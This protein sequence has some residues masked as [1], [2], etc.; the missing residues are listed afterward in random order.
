MWNVSNFVSGVSSVG[1]YSGT[2]TVLTIM[3][4][5]RG[6]TA[7]VLIVFPLLLNLFMVGPSYS[8]VVLFCVY[9][10]VLKRFTFCGWQFVL[11]LYGCQHCR[12][13]SFIGYVDLNG[14]AVWGA[15]TFGRRDISA[16]GV[17]CFAWDR[18]CVGFNFA[19]GSM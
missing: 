13:G 11:Y 12:G 2:S 9:G 14:D 8:A 5:T 1:A 18:I 10:F 15:T 16:R 6:C 7:G 17:F 3:P 4:L 19:D